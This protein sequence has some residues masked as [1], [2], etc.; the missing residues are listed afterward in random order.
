MIY[1]NWIETNIFQHHNRLDLEYF[2]Y[3]YPNNKDI[4]FC[5]Y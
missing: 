1:S 4:L 2:C 5:Y 3:E